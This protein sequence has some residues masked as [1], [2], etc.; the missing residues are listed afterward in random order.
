MKNIPLISKMYAKF[1]AIGGAWKTVLCTQ[2]CSLSFLKKVLTNFIITPQ[3]EVNKTTMAAYQRNRKELQ[4]PFMSGS[5]PVTKAGLSLVSLEIKTFPCPHTKIRQETGN[6]K[7]AAKSMA[8][9]TRAWS[10]FTFLS[11][12]TM[13]HFWIS[14]CLKG[15][16]CR[17]EIIT[18]RL[19]DFHVIS[20][21]ATKYTT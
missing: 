3:D 11:G 15:G 4:I 8:D 2:L 21:N 14:I 1:H 16:H 19:P 17:D 5:S 13:F 9:E 20:P 7:M 18:F 6:V 12:V 10:N